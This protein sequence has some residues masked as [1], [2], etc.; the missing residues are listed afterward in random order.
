MNLYEKGFTFFSRILVVYSIRTIIINFKLG[1]IK[2]KQIFLP[3]T[4]FISAAWYSGTV[5][6][7]KWFFSL[8][9]RSD[10]DEVGNYVFYI[11]MYYVYMC[12]IAENQIGR[13]N[14][15]IDQIQLLVI[16]WIYISKR[17][18]KKRLKKKCARSNFVSCRMCRNLVIHAG[19]LRDPNSILE[20]ALFMM[21]VAKQ[22][23][24]KRTQFWNKFI[25][26]TRI[27]CIKNNHVFFFY[28]NNYGICVAGR[29]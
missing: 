1:F 26:Y 7:F 27:T 10:Y 25:V 29:I 2:L 16:Y 5:S 8:S 15:T 23:R 12:F 20:S 24:N 3:N 11:T 22:N 6:L 18:K 13:S 21:N 28:K 9:C 19:T 17:L 14:L 4:T